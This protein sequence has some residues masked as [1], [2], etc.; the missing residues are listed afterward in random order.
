M[1]ALT[2]GTVDAD[3]LGNFYVCHTGRGFITVFTPDGKLDRV[4][5]SERP[6]MR[7]PR[8]VAVTPR[9]LFVTQMGG[10]T[11]MPVLYFANENG[12]QK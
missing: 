10:T 9:G 7:G 8:G 6:L 3:S 5:R 12:A 2:I 1:R 11:G 4:V